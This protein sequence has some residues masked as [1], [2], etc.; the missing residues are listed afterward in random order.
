MASK[1]VAKAELELKNGT[2]VSVCYYAGTASAE[3]YEAAMDSGDTV[4]FQQQFKKLFD[5]EGDIFR[6]CTKK[7]LMTAT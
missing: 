3:V 7:S 6:V 1:S 2:M 5:A 4:A